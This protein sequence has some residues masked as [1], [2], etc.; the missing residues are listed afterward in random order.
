[1]IKVKKIAVYGDSLALPR[2]GVVKYN[3][4]YFFLIQE[5][6]KNNFIIDYI[7]V[8]DRAKGASTITEILKKY[9]HDA[10][11]YDLPGDIVIFQVGIVDC[12][13]RP[14]NDTRR[15]RIDRLPN[16][17]K[18]IAIKYLHNNRSKIIQNG[19]FYVKTDKEL[20]KIT[21]K[22]ILTK[23]IIDYTNVYV[24]NIC[25]TNKKTEIHSPGF[26]KNIN[27]YN[28]IIY[29]SIQET[30]KTNVHLIDIYTYINDRCEAIDDY[31]VPEDGHHI[32]SHTHR[33]IADII[34]ENE[35][36]CN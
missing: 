25:P 34:I 11:Y 7:E 20:F 29:K 35:M 17:I 26:T 16:W 18:K 15:N 1:M 27:E 32:T 6:L 36:K 33:L 19:K 21:I 22:K 31:I 14:I 10:G 12:A 30:G 8:K 4:R 9:E 24:I 2:K 3:E 28:D 5:W 23:A 13:P